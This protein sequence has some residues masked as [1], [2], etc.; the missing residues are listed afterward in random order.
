MAMSP[1]PVM[2]AVSISELPPCSSPRAATVRM[3]LPRLTRVVGSSRVEVV[4]VART[5]RTA[6]QVSAPSTP[7]TRVRRIAVRSFIGRLLTA[8]T[9]RKSSLLCLLLLRVDDGD[10]VAGVDAFDGDF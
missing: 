6:P 10:H 2:G 4:V 7:R 3:T 9:Q 8:E 1:P 5:I